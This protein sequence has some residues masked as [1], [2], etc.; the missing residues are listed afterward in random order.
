MLLGPMFHPSTKT[1]KLN[2]QLSMKLTSDLL[3]EMD[4]AGAALGYKEK[5]AFYRD[6][7]KAGMIP[8]REKIAQMK[9]GG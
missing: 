3:E 7:L 8:A 6:L 4:A 1:E 2:A 9:E 5:S